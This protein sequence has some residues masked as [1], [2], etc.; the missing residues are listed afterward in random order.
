MLSS[1]PNPTQS[2]RTVLHLSPSVSVAAI[3]CAQRRGLRMQEWLD[4]VVVDACAGGDA[5]NGRAGTLTDEMTIELFAH[6]AS[7]SPGLLTG[8]WKLLFE[9]VLLE[10]TLWD[11]STQTLDELEEQPD[12]SARLNVE[13]LRR[14]WPQLVA[15]SLA[16]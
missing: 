3:V 8:R 6:V 7:Q 9:R 5:E 14:Q 4:K 11:Y 10:D 2:V 15:A 1:Q 13:R 12:C 16:F